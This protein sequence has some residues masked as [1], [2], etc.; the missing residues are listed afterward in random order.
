MRVLKAKAL[1]RLCI[2][3]LE[4]LSRSRASLCWK[5]NILQQSASFPVKTLLST[6]LPAERAA[7]NR[8]CSSLS[9]GVGFHSE[10]PRPQDSGILFLA[11]RTTMGMT[12]WANLLFKIWSSK[13]ED[14][15]KMPKKAGLVKF[16][17]YRRSSR[18]TL[19]QKFDLIEI[20]HLTFNQWTN[21]P[22][23][24]WTNGQKWQWDWL[25]KLLWP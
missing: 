3:T 1:C 16:K 11:T 21:G 15:T 8:L 9:E 24:Q 5:E 19:R 12:T 7:V 18:G 22:M 6:N 10:P 20:W 13:M 23:D 17:N 4:K 25:K 2:F 14:T